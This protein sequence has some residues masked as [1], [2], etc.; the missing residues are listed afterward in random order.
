M[1]IT[2]FELALK[3]QLL[4]EYNKSGVTIL[5]TEER[6]WYLELD[7]S[8]WKLFETEYTISSAATRYG[9]YLRVITDLL[10]VEKLATKYNF[11]IHII[12]P[13]EEPA[14]TTNHNYG[15]LSVI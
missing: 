11:S 12:H 5:Y 9:H 13:F 10:A 1:S 15:I 2:E 4:H 6:V 7:D 3:S 8:D 14:R